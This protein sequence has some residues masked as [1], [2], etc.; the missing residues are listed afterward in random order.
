MSSRLPQTT[1]SLHR[2]SLVLPI[3]TAATLWAAVARFLNLN[4]LPPPAWF[5]EVWYALRA[6]EFLQTGEW[7][8]FYF[9]YFGG[10]N[11][12]PVYMAALAQWFGFTSITLARIGPALAGTLS[13]PLAYACVRE[14]LRGEPIQRF[15]GLP[16]SHRAIAAFSAVVLAYSLFYVTIHRIGMENGVA[17]PTALFIVWQMLRGIRRGKWSGWLLAGLAVGLSQYNGLHARFILPLVAFVGLQ[18]FATAPRAAKSRLALGGGIMVM[19]AVICALPLIRFFTEH[20]E[21]LMGRAAIVTA[22]GPGLRFETIGEMYRYNARMILRVFSVEGSYDP[23]NGVPGVPLLDMVQ[24][25]GLMIGLGWAIIRLPRSPAARKLLVWLMVMTL[26]SFLTEGAPNIGRM[27]GIVPPLAALVAL[28]WVGVYGWLRGRVRPVA[29]RAVAA[30]ALTFSVGWHT[31]LLWAIWPDVPNL[32]EQFTALPVELAEDLIGRAEAG[33][34]TFVEVIPEADEDIVAFNYLFPGTP[35]SRMDFRKCLPLPHHN[36]TRINYLILS[37][38]DSQTAGLLDEWYAVEMPYRE[39]DL[40]QTTGTLVEVLPGAAAPLPA[41]QPVVKF[42]AGLRLYGFEWSGERIRPG[43]TLFLTLYWYTEQPIPE[44]LTA[45]AH[46]G[47]GVDGYPL[48]GQR[49]GQPCLGFYPTSQWQPGVVVAD[50]F[51]ITLAADAPPGEYEV[52][53]GWYRYPSLE[54]LPL[55]A[56]EEGLPDGRAIIGRIRVE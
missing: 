31:Y 26:P 25:V 37:G 22:V 23:K 4:T 13:I 2:R 34:P 7:P 35:V 1:T 18:A 6:R 10:A 50:G 24:S 9:T 41:M 33:E 36:M 45:F 28:G 56:A 39:T 40:F 17:P 51:A 44:D 19:V 27:I 8:V 54:R 32:R 46:I 5:D 42:G 43:E 3:L 49:D 21:M 14:L 12:G 47:R 20:P 30:G 15:V 52:L 11:A 53:V 55:V 38:H 29:L 48:I 16:G